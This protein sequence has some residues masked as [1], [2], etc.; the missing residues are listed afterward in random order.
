MAELLCCKY[1]P[2]ET[3]VTKRNGKFEAEY[4]KEGYSVK[5]VSKDLYLLTK[6]PK[7][8]MVFREGDRDFVF[9]MIDDARRYYAKICKGN[10]IST[11]TVYAFMMSII[12]GKIK[13]S[14]AS[15]GTYVIE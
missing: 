15:D 2:S 7:L 13:V 8:E 4:Q 10:E 11:T 1:I 5:E 12:K 6:G 14:I 3:I 9:D